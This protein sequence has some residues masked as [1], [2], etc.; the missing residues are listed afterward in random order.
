[1]GLQGT[2]V[3][4]CHLAHF[5][6]LA[7]FP[8]P[9]KATTPGRSIEG[10]VFSSYYSIHQH[11]SSRELFFR[12]NTPSRPLPS[13]QTPRIFCSL[14]STG[15]RGFLAFLQRP[16]PAHEGCVGY[17]FGQILVESVTT[18]I[19]DAY[20][21]FRSHVLGSLEVLVGFPVH[22][23]CAPPKRRNFENRHIKQG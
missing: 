20:H 21:F 7:F 5:Q 9:S 8:V 16:S 19:Q 3:N 6:I 14:H 22:C 11:H 4:H 17:I 15:K 23:I 12:Q 13:Y 2:E 1:L 10:S 18:T